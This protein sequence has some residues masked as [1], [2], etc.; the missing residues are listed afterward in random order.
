[1]LNCDTND[2]SYDHQF[3]CFEQRVMDWWFSINCESE[4][5]SWKSD[6]PF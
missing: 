6:F 1:M 5:E 2:N 4:I 3:N